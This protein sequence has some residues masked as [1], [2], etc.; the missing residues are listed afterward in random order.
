V[1]ASLS[2]ENHDIPLEEEQQRLSDAADVGST[3]DRDEP[4]EAPN[5]GT[6]VRRKIFEWFGYPGLIALAVLTVAALA[7][8]NWDKVSELPGVR[9]VIDLVAQEPLPRAS[10]DR[11]AI[12]VAHPRR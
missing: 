7:W 4:Q 9:H 6:D 5:L 1:E 2:S 10:G 8:W 11:Q 3:S 12:A